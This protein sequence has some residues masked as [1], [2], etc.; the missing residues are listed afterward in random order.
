VI[1]TVTLNPALDLT[2]S[3]DELIRH[4][5]HRVRTVTER[6]GGKGLN[7]GRVL[8]AAGEPVLATGLLGGA[9]GARVAEAVG[10]AGVS[11]DFVRIGG[12]TRRT[13][14]VLDSGDATGFWEPGPL[15][16]V[17]EWTRFVERY[18]TLLGRATV[19]VLSGS[20]PPGLPVDAYATLIQLA[21]DRRVPTVLDTSGEP[22][23]HGISAGPDIVKPN[24]AELSTL[25]KDTAATGTDEGIDAERSVGPEEIAAA[26]RALAIG[27]RTVVVS[28]GRR[29]LLALSE[30]EGWQAV[31]PDVI[32]GNPIG[33][34]DACVAALA[35]GLRDGTAWPAILADAVALSAAA[36]AVPVAGGFDR[37]IYER[38][39]SRVVVT[40]LGNRSAQG[41]QDVQLDR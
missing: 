23:R 7:V 32:E 27:C 19:V 1:V 5:T 37:E 21:R 22:L 14:S 40:S 2:Y 20:L 4:A 8:C 28:D 17:G 11:G 15:V 39:R 16:T 9:I 33:A 3:V 36:V 38:L 41:V 25:S 12:E 24:A 31:P 29:G 6:P 10:T 26:L 35:R 18:D 13:V 34:G 30:T